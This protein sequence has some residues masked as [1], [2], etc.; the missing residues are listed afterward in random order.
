MELGLEVPQ[1]LF[2][3]VLPVPA[4]SHSTSSGELPRIVL[5]NTWTLVVSVEPPNS[6][7]DSRIRPPDAADGPVAAFLRITFLEIVESVRPIAATPMPER[8]GPSSPAG[9]ALSLAH[10]LFSVYVM[11][12]SP[13][14]WPS[15]SRMV[16]AQLP[17]TL[18]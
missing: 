11:L 9:Q 17:H 15:S 7:A 18:L 8:A 4:P 1:V 14:G 5:P 3:K 16:P 12:C 10:A 13:P 6:F 2:V